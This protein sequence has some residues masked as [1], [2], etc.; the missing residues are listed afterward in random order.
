[1]L[2]A[3]AER[4]ISPIEDLTRRLGDVVQR[5]RHQGQTLHEYLAEYE[6]ITA[7]LRKDSVEV[8]VAFDPLVSAALSQ[9]RDSVPTATVKAPG[10]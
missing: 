4:P 3:Q 7:E 6:Q 5:I 2:D 1:M 8:H 10:Y 9:Y